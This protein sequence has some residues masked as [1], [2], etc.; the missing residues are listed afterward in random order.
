VVK[1]SVSLVTT[2]SLRAC[3]SSFR[4]GYLPLDCCNCLRAV[5]FAYGLLLMKVPVPIKIYIY[6]YIYDVIVKC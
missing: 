2:L 1:D 6:I 4:A 3:V 5:V